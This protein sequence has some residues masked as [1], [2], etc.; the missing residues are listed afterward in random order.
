MIDIILETK[1]V[2]KTEKNEWKARYQKLLQIH[3][4]LVIDY[5]RLLD[6]K[7]AKLRQEEL[8]S[9]DAVN[10]KG[11]GRA[12]ITHIY[13]SDCCD[14]ILLKDFKGYT[15][16][17]KSVIQKTGKHIDLSKIFEGLED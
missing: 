8:A 16:T 2:D 6:E 15:I 1:E 10:I 12:V 9:G 5:N 11:L 14:C 17:D 3:N 7:M 4:Q 13:N